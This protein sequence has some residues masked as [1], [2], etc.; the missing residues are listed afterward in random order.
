MA[1]DHFKMTILNAFR[2]S[3]VE[4]GQEYALILPGL[5]NPIQ[6]VPS[7]SFKFR[8]YDQRGRLIDELNTGTTIRMTLPSLLDIVLVEL[9]DYTNA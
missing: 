9:G 1:A 8:T 7:L 5:T 3:N 4:G 2:R 6:T